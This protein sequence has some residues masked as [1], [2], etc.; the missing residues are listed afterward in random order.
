MAIIKDITNESGV[1]YNYWKIVN[2]QEL[3]N[4]TN[5]V[6]QAVVTVQGFV[7]K[8]IRL[9]GKSPVVEKQYDLPEFLS[10]NSGELRPD[11]YEALKTVSDFIGATDDLVA[12]EDP[13]I[14]INTPAS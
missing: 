12:P 9:A 13:V 3:R 4:Y 2:Y 14:T 1:T 5:S 8:D 7:D 10:G 6:N 11:L